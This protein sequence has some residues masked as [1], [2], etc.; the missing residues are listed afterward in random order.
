MFRPPDL[1]DLT[2]FQFPELFDGCKNV[3]EALP[4]IAAFL[5]GKEVVVGK[6]TV[7][8]ESATIKGPAI[9]GAN[10]EIR[11]NAYVRGNVIVGDGCVLGNASEFKNCVLFNGCQVPHF[12]YVGDS[13]LGHK[14]HIGAGVILSNLKSVKGTVQV[15]GKDTGLRKFGAIIGDHVEIGCNCV[16]NPGSIIGRDSVLYPG[17]SWRGVCPP[18][19][20]VK[21]RQVQQVVARQS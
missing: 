20:V 11:P 6:G 16:L 3:W 19:S 12:S 2:Q 8:P 14:V 5:K 1:L 9:I 7:V 18:D 10:C 17:V 13:I 21:L 15:E 4:K